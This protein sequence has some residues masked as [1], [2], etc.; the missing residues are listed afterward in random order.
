MCDPHHKFAG[1][2]T[3]N[4]ITPVCYIHEYFVTHKFFIYILSIYKMNTESYFF[5]KC[6]NL[7]Y[8]YHI[9]K[10]KFSLYLITY[11]WTVKV[12]KVH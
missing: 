6:V 7:S 12:Y 3:T 4:I 9:L 11:V 2:M 8:N 1:T 10:C 5:K